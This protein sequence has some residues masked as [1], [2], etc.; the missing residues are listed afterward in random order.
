MATLIKCSISTAR[1]FVY[2]DDNL[3]PVYI[4]ENLSVYREKNLIHIQDISFVPSEFTSTRRE[5]NGS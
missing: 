2:V 5:M 1:L 4:V 3:M